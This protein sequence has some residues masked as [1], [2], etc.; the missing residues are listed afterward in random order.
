MVALVVLVVVVVVLR[1]QC[2]RDVLSFDCLYCTSA[3]LL[4]IHSS[5]RIWVCMKYILMCR[6]DEKPLQKSEEKEETQ[7]SRVMSPPWTSI[8][9]HTLPAS[10]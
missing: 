1:I 2:S 9:R 4:H 7:V 6:I 3:L 8:H 5:K 10:C